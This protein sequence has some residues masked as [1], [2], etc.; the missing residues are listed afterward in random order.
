MLNLSYQKTL[1]I[2][3][4]LLCLVP[5]LTRAQD[6]YDG[7]VINKVTELPIPGVTVILL[8]QKAATQTN[9]RGYFSL[10]PEKPVANDTLQFSSVGYKTFKLPVSA[11]QPQ[12]FILLEASNTQLNEVLI[13]NKKI[14]TITLG[15]FLNYDLK[16]SGKS[17]LFSHTVRVVASPMP[18]AKL[19]TAPKANAI[20]TGIAMGRQDLPES[21]TYAIRNK[22]TTFLIHVMAQ[23]TDTGGPGKVLF[24]KTV[25]LT[26]NSTRIDFD[27][28]DR[29]LIIPGS[30]FF[31][32]IEWMYIPYNE[33]I[34]IGNA[35]KVKR[36]TKR[37][38]QVLEDTAGYG[39]MYQPFLVGY[40]NEITKKPAVLYTKVDDNWQIA[41]E[42]RSFD[43]ALSATVHY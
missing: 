16:N 21:P 5:K 38:R 32:A 18:L 1:L 26:D 13:S 37:G 2:I 23:D 39:I 6:V 8:K 20:L 41:R 12:M 7:Q 25:S 33:I 35:D 42:Y 30:K 4:A 29:F 14:K 19:F 3:V 24:T 31:I 22:F 10:S 27:L 28:T 43:V 40:E 9:E 11:Y 17:G 34:S 36:L 15:R